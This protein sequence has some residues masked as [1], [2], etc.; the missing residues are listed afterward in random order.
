MK[1]RIMRMAGIQETKRSA[2]KEEGVCVTKE[3]KR[4]NQMR[5]LAN[6]NERWN[7]SASSRRARLDGNRGR[8]LRPGTPRARVRHEI[9][10]KKLES[11]SGQPLERDLNWDDLDGYP[12]PAE[13]PADVAVRP[14]LY[15]FYFVLM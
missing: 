4:D 6:W 12:W 7:I 9:D 1:I 10:R 14:C 8:D 3:L 5:E 2:A 15:L 13:W 11:R